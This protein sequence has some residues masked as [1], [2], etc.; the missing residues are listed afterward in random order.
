MIPQ[1]R[2]FTLPSIYLIRYFLFLFILL[3]ALK[4]A[5]MD[6]VWAVVGL[7]IPK[8]VILGGNLFTRCLGGAAQGKLLQPGAGKGGRERKVKFCKERREIGLKPVFNGR[9]CRL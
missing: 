9:T 3:V 1:E 6:F 5:D 8:A 7:L 4:R 2:A